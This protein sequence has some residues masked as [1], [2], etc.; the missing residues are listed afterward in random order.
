MENPIILEFSDVA[1]RSETG[2]AA[3]VTGISFAACAGDLILI[4]LG[5]HSGYV[6][7]SECAEGLTDP[8]QGY[9]EFLGQRWEGMDQPRQCDMRG[10]IGRVFHDH[11]WVS[12]LSVYDNVALSQRHHT[13]RSEADIRQEVDHLA[14]TVGAFPLPEQLPDSVPS[15]ELKRAEWVRAL[16][17]RPQLV[18]LE[19]PEHGMPNDSVEQLVDAVLA[20]ATNG[21]AVLWM[22]ASGNCWNDKRLT[23]ARRFSIENGRW[24][25]AAEIKA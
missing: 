14:R 2:H 10:R 6:P 22:T 9:V 21:S 18:L 16:L 1:L 7:F 24:T 19:Q 25:P 17:G 3:D 8:E 23:T 12:N 4:L 15:I 11:G 13:L 5:S 20:A